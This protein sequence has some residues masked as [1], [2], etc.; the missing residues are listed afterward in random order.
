MADYKVNFILMLIGFVLN[1]CNIWK[2]GYVKT[3]S[4]EVVWLDQ[5][6]IIPPQEH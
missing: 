5:A 6:V 3:I 1:K 4:D 2:C